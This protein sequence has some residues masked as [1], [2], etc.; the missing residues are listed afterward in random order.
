MNVNIGAVDSTIVIFYM[1]AVLA[2]GLWVGRNKKSSSDY[3]L[4]DRS[5][6]WGAVLLSIVATETSTVTFLS[7]P[8]LAAAAGGNLTFLQ[9]T[10]GYI[11][12]RIAVVFVLLPLYFKGQPFTAYEVLESRFGKM[13]RRTASSLFLVTRNVSDSLRLFLTAM[14]LQIVLGL[15]LT[16]SVI[17]IGTVTILYTFI[18]GAKSVI[19][20]DCIQFVIYMLGA[21]AAAAIILDITPGGLQEVLRFAAVEQKL[22]IFDF[23]TSL[24]KP[25]MT[26]WAGLAGGAFLTAATHGTDQ[27]MV[28]RYLSAR[29]QSEASLALGISGF[30]VLLQ[31]AMFLLI[32]IGLVS[33]FG[34]LGDVA[35]T[36][37]LKNDQLFAYFIVNYMPVGLLGLTLAAVFAAAMSTLSSSLNSSAAAFINDLYLPL[38]R[39]ETD[40]RSKLRAGQAATVAF[41]VLQT[42]L[43]ILF[44]LVGTDESTV[45]NV[46]KISGFAIGPVLGLYFL[47][48]FA[49]RVAQRA[50]LSGFIAG[51]AILSF[52]AM[53]TPVYWAWYAMLGSLAT[54][55]TGVLAQL[56]YGWKP[57]VTQE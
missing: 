5:L 4:G 57:G 31:F 56:L 49:P 2:F 30:V 15:D 21:A 19:W 16:V 6:P 43:A 50:A 1:L 11:V 35:E 12:G 44:G 25:T 53:A 20:N 36:S 48:V 3:F 13:S 14:V 17:F 38:R 34:S 52:V 24:F 32:G 51:V 18:G 55:G 9:I 28:Q 10:I 39:N 7:I 37:A 29:N 23:D 40:E 22:Q 47:A 46:L 45:S 26:F 8:G 41:G 42:S 33:L 54:L 27:L